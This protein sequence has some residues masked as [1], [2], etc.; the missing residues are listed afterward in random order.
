MQSSSNKSSKQV[1][2]NTGRSLTLFSPDW[3]S[4]IN[5]SDLPLMAPRTTAWEAENPTQ[6]SESPVFN[7]DLCTFWIG[8]ISVT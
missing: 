2:I 7:M 3:A 8:W 6:D 1:N 5:D 4:E